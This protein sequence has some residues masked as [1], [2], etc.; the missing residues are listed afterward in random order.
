MRLSAFEC[1]NLLSLSKSLSL[2]DGLHSSAVT[3]SGR[4]EGAGGLVQSVGDN[5][6]LQ[7]I[8]EEALHVVGEGLVLL[9]SGL[10]GVLGVLILSVA[11]IDFHSVLGEV[12]HFVFAVVLGHAVHSV[13]VDGVDHVQDFISFVIKGILTI[14]QH[15]LQ[16]EQDSRCLIPLS[17]DGLDEWALLDRL[18]AVSGKIEDLV[19]S[20]LHA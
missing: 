9:L 18:L 14:T 5:N 11:I 13:L 12:G 15:K 3:V 6:L 2:H 4:D 19:L 1:V 10:L 7:L 16:Q 17:D 20:L 8:G